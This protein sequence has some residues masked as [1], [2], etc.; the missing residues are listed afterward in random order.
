MRYFCGSVYNMINF[1]TVWE[2]VITKEFVVDLY[3]SDR[4]HAGD[5]PY[6]QNAYLFVYWLCFEL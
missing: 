6:S 3:R 1:I 2:H 5:K 4:F